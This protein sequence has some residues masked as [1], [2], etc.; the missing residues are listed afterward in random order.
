MDSGEESP[1]LLASA[2][3]ALL[4]LVFAALVLLPLGEIALRAVAGVGFQGSSSLVQHLTFAIGILGA[5]V[6]A[7]HGRL[8]GF[9]AATLVAG[10]AAGIAR[11]FS[12]SI[13]AA[14]T[15][16][17]CLASAQFVEAERAAGKILAHGIPVWVVESLLPAGFALITLRL[18]LHSADRTAARVGA[19]LLAAGVLALVFL[20]PL[21]P[22]ALVAPGLLALLAAMLLGAPLFAVIGGA[23]LLLLWES[24][25]PIASVAVNHYGLTANPSLPAIPLFTLAGYFLAESGSP[26]RLIELFDALFGRFRGG[27]AVVTV[28]AC[29]FF[30]SFTGASGVAILA[31]GGLAMPLLLAA[32]YPQRP[33]LG[34][35]TGGGLPGVLLFPALPLLLYA[36]VAKTS[37]ESMFVGGFLP[38]LLMLG[39]ALWWGIRQAPRQVGPARPFDPDRARRALWAAKWDLSLPV[40]PLA[41]L[42]GGLATPVEAAAATALYAYGIAAVIHRDVHPLRDAPRIMTE[43]GLLVG[44]ILLILGVSLGFTNYMVD[45]Q[46]PDRAVEWVTRHIQS[47]WAFLLALNGFLLLV[48]CV[49][50]IFSAIVVITPLIV[51]IGLAFGVHPVHLG[52][53]FLANL[54]IG[55]L[56]PPIGLN[57]FFASYRFGRPLPEVCRSVMPLFFVLCAGVLAITYLP[58]LSTGLPGLVR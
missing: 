21:P 37:I 28:L 5:A 18:L 49:M 24:G 53:I 6:A 15:A 7:R 50:D 45:A 10:S 3:N 16:I 33:A 20:L 35:V 11:F 57:L 51:P 41:A 55:Y 40:V 17:L 47:P 48:G 14:V 56:T 54:E 23:A 34:L 30:T 12:S 38:T 58:W 1:A 46:V 42:L 8:L 2:E 52:M 29:T 19:A 25:V 31:I 22:R 39:I 9:S 44:G 27:A 13:A 26:R 32:G 4:S 36:I 43:C